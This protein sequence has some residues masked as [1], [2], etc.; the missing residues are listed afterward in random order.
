MN[1]V[2]DSDEGKLIFSGNPYH[3]ITKSDKKYNTLDYAGKCTIDFPSPAVYELYSEET[4]TAFTIT[5]MGASF[6][7]LAKTVH[8]GSKFHLGLQESFAS[9]A[10]YLIH[11]A[12]KFNQNPFLYLNYKIYAAGNS[13]FFECRFKGEEYEPVIEAGRLTGIDVTVVSGF[14]DLVLQNENY[15]SG[16]SLILDDEFVADAEKNGLPDYVG[17]SYM[18]NVL[19]DFDISKYLYKPDINKLA[20]PA[21]AKK[22][23]ASALSVLT[24]DNYGSTPIKYYNTV[25]S[26]YKVIHARLSDEMLAQI[27]TSGTLQAYIDATVYATSQ[28]RTKRISKFTPEFL[29]AFVTATNNPPNFYVTIYKSD[30]TAVEN[31][32][33]YQTS[34]VSLYDI[35]MVNVSFNVIQNL[36][37]ETDIVSYKVWASQYPVNFEIFTYIVDPLQRINERHIIARTQF[38]GYDTIRLTGKAEYARDV[39][40]EYL[41]KE[42]INIYNAF[43]HINTVNNRSITINTGH[44]TNDEARWIASLLTSDDVYFHLPETVNNISTNALVPIKLGNTKP[45]YNKDGEYLDNFDVVIDK[46]LLNNL[47]QKSVSTNLVI[48]SISGYD[49]SE[50][51]P[52]STLTLT[53]A[54]SGGTGIYT[55]KWFVDEVETDTGIEVDLTIDANCSIYYQVYD[56]INTLTS[57][58]INVSVKKL[59]HTNFNPGS[60]FCDIQFINSSNGI[61]ITFEGSIFKTSDGGNTWQENSTY[62]INNTNVFRNLHFVNSSTCYIVGYSYTILKTINGGETWSELTGPT[63]PISSVFF[64]NSLTGYIGEIEGNIY[65]TTD[66]GTTWENL[67]QSNGTINCIYF[68][69]ENIGWACGPFGRV[70]KTNDGGESWTIQTTG[71]SATLN[72][73][74]FTDSQNGFAVGSYG[75]V[76]KTT[77][78]GSSWSNV[79]L[80]TT[81]ELMDIQLVDGFGFIVSNYGFIFKTTDGG[82]NWNIEEGVDIPELYAVSIYDVNLAWAASS[83][84]II[85]YY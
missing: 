73:I 5:V 68:F 38:G 67:T 70:L 47:N 7:Y 82:A 59:W 12:A 45:K 55:V 52:G 72:S 41:D 11:V 64:I 54:P 53:A 69:N 20:Y 26:G 81:A 79:S 9:L 3:I 37:N 62:K 27:K 85:K 30:G 21:T 84:E 13:L 51:Q 19:A 8:S 42:I 10:A 50:I 6:V 24:Y 29:C 71:V 76:I 43:E 75:V 25:T 32:L 14:T 44:I 15:T 17:S 1:I 83:S 66:G 28:P 46:V 34:N 49:N 63:N 80:N 22:L 65:K 33:L 48:G 77:D 35:I 56:G 2:I 4:D 57:E 39:K 78:G 36:L 61:A 40:K 23:S 74:I 18:A 31:I 60:S 16:L 58:T